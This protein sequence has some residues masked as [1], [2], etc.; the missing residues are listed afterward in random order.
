M[1]PLRTLTLLQNRQLTFGSG[2]AKEGLESYLLS[3]PFRSI[4]IVAAR[5]SRALVEDLASHLRLQGRNV[6]CDYSCTKEPTTVVFE[7][8]RKQAVIFG[9]ECVVGFGGGSVLD[10]AKLVAAL[11]GSAEHIENAFG[12]GL[13]QKRML[14]LVCVPTTSGTGSEV[15]PNAI[16]LDETDHMKKGVI[17]RFLVPD[18]AFVDPALTKSLPPRVTAFTGVDALTHCI[19]AYTNKF[20]HPLVDMYAL[21]GI[22][23]IA[24][25]LRRAVH[26]ADDLEAREG[27]AMASMLGGLC[28]GPVNTAAVHALAYP[29]GTDYGIAHG[30]SNAILLPE[31]FRFNSSASPSR[32]AE[33]A[34]ALGVPHDSDAL[35]LSEKGADLLQGL[36]EDIGICSLPDG[37]KLEPS[38]LQSMAE[39]ASKITRLMNNNPRSLSIDD[40]VGIYRRSFSKLR[41]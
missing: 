24:K 23:L 8:S 18:A 20:A 32:H 38:A 19:E 28:L 16:L 29:L 1:S 14:P 4:Y 26:E 31:V 10:L 36:L 37:L 6:S 17:S 2:C 39:S 13:L 25:Y 27:M 5:S 30:L 34:V 33:V 35:E 3:H 12:I 41:S 11:A 21:E 7:V 22:R 15:S 9:A 40:M